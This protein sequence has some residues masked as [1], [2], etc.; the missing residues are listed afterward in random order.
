MRAGQEAGNLETAKVLRRTFNRVAGRRDKCTQETSH[1]MLSLPY[2]FCSHSFYNVNLSSMLRKVNVEAS[3]PAAPAVLSNL[4]DLYGARMDAA[5]WESQEM[6]ATASPSLLNMCLTSFVRQFTR[7][8]E[9]RITAR[10][11]KGDCIPLF[12]PEYKSTRGENYY[13]HCL[14]ALLRFLPWTGIP[15]TVFQGVA[16]QCHSMD[17]IPGPQRDDIIQRW[18]AF[19]TAPRAGGPDEAVTRAVDL[20]QS[21]HER[22]EIELEFG[23]GPGG[24]TAHLLLFVY[25]IPSPLL[26]PPSS[27]LRTHKNLQ[28]HLALMYSSL[29]FA[30]GK[31]TAFLATVFLF[32][33]LACTGLS[34][35]EDGQPEFADI[36]RSFL[37]AEHDGGCLETPWDEGTDFTVPDRTYADCNC[38]RFVAGQGG[39]EFSVQHVDSKWDFI[40]STPAF[41]QSRDRP[42]RHLAVRL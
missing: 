2:V 30:G 15:E 13:K 12:T 31:S 4:L 11:G 22:D 42:K 41:R 8:K 21:A 7:S 17:T 14:V 23:T 20:L 32:M 26:L 25:R 18:E 24:N 3:D 37:A 39:G 5:S 1:L 27:L 36:F 19:L 28:Y 16:G 9:A 40:K 34:H 10:K 38:G 29:W 6:F 35:D 33:L